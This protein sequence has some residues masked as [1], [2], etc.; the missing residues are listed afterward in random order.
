[1]YKKKKT[2]EKEDRKEVKRYVGSEKIGG[3]IF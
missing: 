1:M 3:R 2:R